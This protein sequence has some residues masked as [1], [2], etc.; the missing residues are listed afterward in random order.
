MDG[1]KIIS[2]IVE[3]LDI[4]DSLNFLHMSLKSMQKSFD[5]T[6]KKGY[7]PHFINKANNLDYLG[8]YPEHKYYGAEY[9]YQTMREP[10]YLNGIRSKKRNVFAISWSYCPTVWAMSKY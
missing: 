9:I 1:T 5:L 4:L 8:L 2:M 3:Y 6:C 10:I 7:Y